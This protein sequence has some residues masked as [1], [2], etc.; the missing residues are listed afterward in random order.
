VARTTV[1][2]FPYT[3][4]SPDLYAISAVVIWPGIFSGLPFRAFE[5]MERFAEP[6]RSISRST[7]EYGLVVRE[8]VRWMLWRILP[9][10][11]ASMS[12]SDMPE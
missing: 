1:V 10:F 5:K 8:R 9:W 3:W 7:S 2:A 4:L 6:R 11:L 12:A